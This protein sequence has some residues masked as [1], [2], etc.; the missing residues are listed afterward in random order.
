MKLKAVMEFCPR[1]LSRM[2]DTEDFHDREE[3][4]VITETLAWD[5]LTGMQLDRG[6]VEEARQ[7]KKSS[8]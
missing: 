7:K 5:D 3:A 4:R 6:K 8:T 2:P 1:K